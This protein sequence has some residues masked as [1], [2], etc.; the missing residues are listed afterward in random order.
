MAFISAVLTP[1]SLFVALCDKVTII[2]KINQVEL[3]YRLLEWS[4]LQS[5]KTSITV[6]NTNV[7]LK[8]ALALIT[9]EDI[10][11]QPLKR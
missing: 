3:F 7:H 6:S 1:L 2:L 11:D 9:E 5:F 4:I 10:V 8:L